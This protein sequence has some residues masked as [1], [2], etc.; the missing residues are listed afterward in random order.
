VRDFYYLGAAEIYDP[1]LGTWSLT[2]PLSNPGDYQ[3]AT[4]L[5]DGRVLVAGGYN[6]HRN[7]FLATAARYSGQA[8]PPD[9]ACGATDGAW[10]NSNVTIACTAS[11]PES[12]LVNA[13]DASFT[14]TTSVSI[15]NETADARTNS[16]Q[17]CNTVGDCA[18][19]GPIVGNKV[20]RRPP[21]T[22]VASPSANV[23]YEAGAS[24]PAIYDCSD[25][26]SGVGL[27][28]GIGAERQSNRNIV[29][30]S[31]DVLAHIDGQCG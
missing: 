9:I 15:G 13:A 31:Q 16:R 12:G 1:G 8:T 18:L 29:R 25:L 19:A 14:L 22:G 7:T 27:V 28:P 10:H 4:L 2:D 23:T 11:D 21:L 26:G 17:V 30:R 6:E 5:S 20:D 3:T 24:T